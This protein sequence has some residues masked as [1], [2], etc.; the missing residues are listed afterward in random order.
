M[1]GS[2]PGSTISGILQA[3]ILEWVAISFSNAC[4]W[5]V[6]VKS[7]SCVQLFTT[8]W[9]A[10]YQATLSMEFSTK[11]TGVGCHCLLWSLATLPLFPSLV[12]LILYSTSQIVS[13]PSSFW[14]HVS[15]YQFPGISSSHSFNLK[16]LTWGST[17]DV[18]PLQYNL[19]FTYSYATVR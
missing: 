4:K 14:S 8:P 3:R 10:A 16:L 6:K 15:L 18:F 1:D 9:T 7:L 17:Y 11:S 2:P 12:S 5:K 13:H 19:D